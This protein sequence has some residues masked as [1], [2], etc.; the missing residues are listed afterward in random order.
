MKIQEI[1]IEGLKASCRQLS[2]K[3]QKICRIAAAA[4][5]R[6]DVLNERLNARAKQGIVVEGEIK[7]DPE[8]VNVGNQITYMFMW[9]MYLYIFIVYICAISEFIFAIGISISSLSSIATTLRFIF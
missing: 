1:H 3:I 2:A 7:S 5:Y 6:D 8:D 4:K 9:G